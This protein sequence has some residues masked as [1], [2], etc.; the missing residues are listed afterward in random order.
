MLTITNEQE[1]SKNIVEENGYSF[2]VLIDADGSVSGSFGVS[3]I[4]RI[5]VIDQQGKIA[6]VYI[7][8][9]EDIK[10]ILAKDIARLRGE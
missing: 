4:P 10:D 5:F 3:T 7:G 1:E 8:F 2:P 6:A 9:H